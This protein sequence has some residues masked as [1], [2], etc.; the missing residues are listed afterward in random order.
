MPT[1]IGEARRIVLDHLGNRYYRH[2][3]DGWEFV[4]FAMENLSDL[5][6]I[7]PPQRR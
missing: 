2:F 1:C 4:H 7:S 6:L 3:A 5:D